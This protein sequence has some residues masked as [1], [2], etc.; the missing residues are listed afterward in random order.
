MI[1]CWICGDEGTTGEHI[2]KALDLKSLY[3]NV[4][5]RHPLFLHTN[6]RRNQRIGSINKSDK[7]KSK[8]LICK[9]CNNARTAPH[10]NAW[11]PS[12]LSKQIR[13]DTI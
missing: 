3:K 4:S 11:H 2:I 13:F 12:S 7:L 6:V 5:Q 10:D 9:H 1:K 8:A